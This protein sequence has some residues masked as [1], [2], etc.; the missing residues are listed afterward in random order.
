MMD[1]VSVFPHLPGS[2]DFIRGAASAASACLRLPPPRPPPP[3]TLPVGPQLQV[4][5]VRIYFR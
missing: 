5:D 3:R 4:Q 1:I 2:L